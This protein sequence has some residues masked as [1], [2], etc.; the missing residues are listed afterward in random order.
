MPKKSMDKKGDVGTIDKQKN[1]LQPP[2]KFK[3]ILHNDDFTS[4]DFVERLL[5]QLFHK[6]PL[7]AKGIARS[8]HETGKGIAGVYP[9]GIAETKAHQVNAIARS[10]QVPLLSE[11]EP[12]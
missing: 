8:I 12:E 2:R 6:P 3:V 5:I 7:V 9:K 1:K 4:F 10:N 11:I